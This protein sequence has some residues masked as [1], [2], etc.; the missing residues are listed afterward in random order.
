[1]QTMITDHEPNTQQAKK[2]YTRHKN[3]GG[4]SLW[5]H[6]EPMNILSVDEKKKSGIALCH[7]N[8]FGLYRHLWLK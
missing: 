7:A 8:H 4:K 1:M 6:V 5:R 2:K 3:G